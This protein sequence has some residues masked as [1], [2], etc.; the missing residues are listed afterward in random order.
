MGGETRGGG[1]WGGGG[2]ACAAGDG[3]AADG[4]GGGGL[5]VGGWGCGGGRLG[6]CGECEC[7]RCAWEVKEKKAGDDREGGGEWE[8]V[9]G[10]GA[11][12]KITPVKAG[13]RGAISPGV[14]APQEGAGY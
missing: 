12:E 10:E 7:G 9:W 5:G 14:V 13:G 4:G 6:G 11:G 8:R 2:F 1:D 3:S